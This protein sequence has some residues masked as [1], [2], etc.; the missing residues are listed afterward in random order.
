MK[1]PHIPQDAPYS[2]SQ[3]AWLNGFFAGMRTHMIQSAGTTSQADARVIN[4]LYG[5]QTGNSESV[6]NDAAATAKAHGL[7]PVVKSMDEIEIDALVKMEYLLVITSTYGEGEMPDNAQMLW[8]AVSSDSAPQLPQM[9]FSVLA[10]G[11]TS[12]DL[13]CQAGINWDNRLEQLGAERVYDRVDCDV[14]FEESAENWISA[15]IPHMAEGVSTTAVIVDTEAAAV[16]APKFSRKNPFPAKMRVNRLLTDENSSKETR[17]YEIS[18]AG[19]SRPSAA[20]A[21]RMCLSMAT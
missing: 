15:V 5:S 9:K 21:T 7:K 14:D 8:D 18:I 20:K 1:T 4:I 16:E 3:R 12:Y 17:H 11:D 10:L 19:S 2:E 6:A 13:F